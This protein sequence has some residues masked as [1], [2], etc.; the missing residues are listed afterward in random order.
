MGR[1]AKARRRED[2]SDVTID[3]AEKPERAEELEAV[4]HAIRERPR[5]VGNVGDPLLPVEVGALHACRPGSRRQDLR[6]R[7]EPQ[8]RVAKKRG[9][10]GSGVDVVVV[11]LCSDRPGQEKRDT[12]GNRSN[13]KESAYRTERPRHRYLVLEMKAKKGPGR[14]P[15]HP[16]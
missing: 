12:A 11:A 16:A 9:A 13:A 5:I 4:A 2:R 1:P 3:A 14:C 8:A 10:R 6:G 7:D 15:D